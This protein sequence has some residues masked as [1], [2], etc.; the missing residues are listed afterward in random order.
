MQPNSTALAQPSIPPE[1]G[2]IEEVKELVGS[3]TFDHWFQGKASIEI[4]DDQVTIG[5]ENPFLLSWMQHRFRPAVAEAARRVLGASAEVRFETRPTGPVKI[6]PA[7]QTSQPSPQLLEQPNA[8]LS[9]S[10]DNDRHPSASLSRRE[11][12]V[13]KC[14]PDLPVLRNATAPCSPI[15]ECSPTGQ[16][17]PTA[18]RSPTI[19]RS[20]PTAAPPSGHTQSGH[21]QSGRTQSGRTQPSS[22]QQSNRRFADLADFVKGPGNELALTAAL[23]ICELPGSR[24]NPLVLYGGVG[25]GKTHLLEATYRRLRAR[26]PALHV[27]FLSAEGFANHFTQAL[28]DRSLPSF[29]QRFRSVDVL[30]IDDVDFLD[31][32]RVIQE[33]FLHTIKQL[34][35][36]ERQIVLSTDRHPRLLTKLSEELVTRFIAGIVCRM[37][38]PDLET[39]RV[40]VARKAARL[41]SRVSE[42]ALELVAQRFRTSVREIEGALNC[43]ETY[44]LMTGKTVGLSI[45]RQVLADLERDC[46][47]VVRLSD[48]EQTVCRFFAVGPEELRSP[49]RSRSVSQ[50]RMLAMY[51]ARKMTQAA[52]SEIGEYFGGRNHSTVMSAEKR[53]RDLLAS[54]VTVRVAAQSWKLGD[55]MS[56]LEQQLL[57]G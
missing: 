46:V 21:T 3:Q 23:Q 6:D 51:L 49:R 13:R 43:L 56:S 37:E 5:I 35:S 28:R 22:T 27:L 42:E 20:A 47:R 15:A 38:P 16:R 11:G 14:R 18:Q 52:Y 10:R 45:A 30:V 17:G 19:E 25:T 24:Y 33:E 44:G 50:P 2:M 36:H 39:R 41:T 26:N 12:A 32:K 29:R 55:L 53:V 9:L 8:A 7:K 1:R 54:Q 40:I 34:E 4:A 31:G 57:T 48:V